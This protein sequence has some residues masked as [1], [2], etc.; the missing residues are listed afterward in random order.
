[1]IISA[2][3]FTRSVVAFWLH[4]LILF[5]LHTALFAG[6][7]A[8]Q[9]PHIDVQETQPLRV[10]H[11]GDPA[12]VQALVSGAAQPLSSASADIDE[13]GV[14]DLLV[15]Y[16]TPAGGVVVLYRGNLDA[17]APQSRASFLAIGR[18]EF[19]S[20]F[21]PEAQVFNVPIRPDFL[22]TGNFTGSGHLD[23][24]LA[25]RGGDS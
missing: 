5:C 19:P 23:L 18:S 15:G 6:G 10:N 25:S 11:L 3:R 9:G 4:V 8:P 12:A 16:G 22:A 21:L 1:M 17:F 2:E 24:L 13:D 7:P 20:P 14:A